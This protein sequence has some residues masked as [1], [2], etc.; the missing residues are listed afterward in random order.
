M[1]AFKAS[2]TG[3][4]VA[5]IWNQFGYSRV[6][7]EAGSL[8]GRYSA[9]DP[10]RTQ[11][12]AKIVWR[13]QQ[14]RLEMQMAAVTGLRNSESF[15][16][17]AAGATPPLRMTVLKDDSRRDDSPRDVVRALWLDVAFVISTSRMSD[18]GAVGNANGG[19]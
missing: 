1:L 10:E 17:G 12:D 2:R 11:R 18:G 19:G 9:F 15:D 13:I 7:R 16:S 6:S 5:N 4:S 3:A 8:Q 14:L